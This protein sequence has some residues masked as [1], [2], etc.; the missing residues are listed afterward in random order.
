MRF[1]LLALSLLIAAPAS[2][3]DFS[4]PAEEFDWHTYPKDMSGYTEDAEFENV[5]ELGVGGQLHIR[6]WINAELH[7]YATNL[8]D[9]DTTFEV[10]ATVANLDDGITNIVRINHPNPVFNNPHTLESNQYETL[11]SK[12]GKFSDVLRSAGLKVVSGSQGPVEVRAVFFRTIQESDQLTTETSSSWELDLYRSPQTIRPNG[13]PTYLTNEQAWAV[14]TIGNVVYVGGDFKN[15]KNGEVL[16]DPAQKYIA[17][18]NRITGDPIPDFAIELDGEVYAL[19]ASPNND[20][21]YIGGAFNTANGQN[22]KKFAAYELVNDQ[23]I[24]TNFRLKRDTEN[25]SPDKALRDIAV[26]HDKLYLAGSFTKIGGNEDHAYVA[27]FDRDSGEIVQT[28]TPKPNKQVKTRIADGDEGLWIGGDF[29]RVNGTPKVGLALVNKETG[30]L[31][32]SPT[33]PY[34]VIDLAA[35]PTQ[36]FV[37]SGGQNR[38]DRF[39]GNIAGAFNRI[40]QEKQWEL[41]GNGNVQAVDVDDG[42]YVYFGGHYERFRYIRNSDTDPSG[43]WI[44]EGGEVDRL[45]RHDKVTGEIDLTWLPFVD[46]IRS[47]NGVDVTTDGLYIVG[48]FF[49]VGGDTAIT[50]DP[51][52]QNHRGFAMFDGATN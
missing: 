18:F 11:C 48:D 38:T 34:T 13:K 42:R 20:M 44:K 23:P 45:S 10:C 8:K 5:R 1:V 14:L 30:E 31:E 6:H 37:A 12:Q 52:R 40:T 28:F 33:V 32:T 26:T 19:A 15:I 9:N 7:N 29:K 39:T 16:A 49:V 50:N 35:T 36:L 47:V 2:A 43:E 25:I 24:L 27:A 17:A 41:Q 3:Q 21:L 51:R 4:I 46:G 22:R